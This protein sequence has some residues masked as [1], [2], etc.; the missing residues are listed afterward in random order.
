MIQGGGFEPG[1]KQKPTDA[2]IENEADNGLKNDKRHRRHGAHQRPALGHRAV[3]HQRRRQRLPRTTRRRARRAGATPCS[4][5][6]SRAWTSSTRSR[7]VKTGS[8]GGHGDVPLEDVVIEKGRRRLSLRSASRHGALPI[9]PPGS[10]RPPAGAAIDFISRPAPEAGARPRPSR[11][12]GATCTTTPADAA[13]HPRRPVRG[14]GRRRRA[15]R[16]GFEAR[17][18][19]DRCSERRARACRSSSCTATA[20]SWSAPRSREPAGVSRSPDPTVLVRSAPAVAARAR[21]CPVP[22]DVAYLVPPRGARSGLAARFL[23]RPLAER[24]AI[25]TRDAR[26]KRART[27]HGKTGRMGRCRHR[28]PRSPGCNAGE[29]QR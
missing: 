9:E 23:A 13:L 12:G 6:S 1:M 28:R 15:Q 8:K 10:S 20:T 22:G 19:R 11:P 5:R 25:G 21:R 14:L 27:R 7:S 4:A 2:P 3:L 16:T 18:R 26:R 29:R 24:R 17:V